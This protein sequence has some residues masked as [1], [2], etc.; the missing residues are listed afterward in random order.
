MKELGKKIL[1]IFLVISTIQSVFAQDETAGNIRGKVFSGPDGPLIGVN[2]FEIDASNRIHTSQ[3][4]NINGEFSMKVKNTANKLKVS[5][6]GYKTQLIPIGGKKVFSIELVDATTIDVVVVKARKT[7]NSGGLDIPKKEISTAMQTISS[8]EFE[9][10]SVASVDDAL[11]G[12][13]SGLDIVSNSGNTGSGASMRIRGITSINSSSEPLIVLNGIIFETNNGANMDYA[14]PNQE[15]FADLLSVNVDD[16]ESI[17]VLKDA[18]STA[19]WGS[20]GANGVISII[21]KKGFSGKTKVVYTYRFSGATQPKGM[22]MLTGDDYT[23]LLKESYF[24]PKQSDNTSNIKELNYNPLFSEYH[25]YNQNTDWVKAVTQF[26][27]TN[28]HYLQLSGGGERARFSVS[29][30]FF[31]QTGS[32]IGQLLKRYSTRMNLD[33]MVSERIKFTSEFSFTYSD[34]K[35]NIANLLSTA[36]K[37]MPNMSIYARDADGN[38]TDRFYKMLPTISSQLGDQLGYINPVA[39]GYLGQSNS[40]SIRIIPTFR[41]Q[42][43][44]I[45]PAK[46]QLRYKGH[47]SFDVNNGGGTAFIPKEL[48]TS[49][50]LSSAINASSSADYRGLSISAENSLTWV[51][52]FDNTNHSLMMFINSKFGTSTYRSQSISAYGT[53]NG[54]I[55]GP[56][57]GGYISGL[58]SSPGQGRSMSMSFVTHYAFKEKYIMDVSLTRYGST[59]FGDSRKWGTFPGVSLAWNV[60]DE[61]FMN[62]IKSWLSTFKLRPSWGIAGTEP[63]GEYLFYSL[64]SSW[65]RYIDLNAVRPDN[66]QLANLRWEKSTLYNYGFD[67]GLM[68]DAFMVYF[69]Y[70]YKRIEDMLFPNVQIPSSSGFTGL[71]FQ[72]AGTMDNNGWEINLQAN[73]LIKAGDFSVDV[74]LNFSNNVN[75]IVNIRPSILAGFNPD[76]NFEN[77]TYLTRIQEKNPYGAIYGFRYKGVYQF[78]E[79]H[80]S[81]DGT[82][83]FAFDE[84]KNVIR[85][86]EGKPLRMTFGAGRNGSLSLYDFKGGDA[87]YEDINHDGTINELDIVYLGN[88]NPLVNGG[89]NLKFNYKRFSMSVFSNFRVGNKVV[90]ANRML[91]ENMYTNNNQSASVNWRWR[92]DGDY[93]FMP[94]ALNKTGYNW[95]GSDRYVED[96]S[97]FRVKNLQINYALPS[98]TLKPYAINGLS[99][100]LTINNLFVLT[101]YSGVDPEVG[102]GGFGI[103]RDYGQTPRA[104]SFTAGLSVTF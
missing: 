56:T 71:S 44:L 88:S 37:I 23:M 4:T 1:L 77:G 98:K 87:I 95:L 33:Y 53:P 62:P 91:A 35:Q 32:V 92:K 42:Y 14:N 19:V 74:T 73:K 54:S 2:V 43:D 10:L 27:Q 16:I 5:Y 51:P 45:D 12:R 61:E 81:S 103:S 89:F 57:A 70:Y 11:Q 93:T 17:T 58:N 47:V 34:N 8:K 79:Y 60:A 82:S 46:Q 29:G 83:P 76:Y 30:G 13:I 69:D 67:L 49:D 36:Y 7:I 80:P 102:T 15:Q 59:R 85:D 28:D 39:A 22:T 48:S 25:N 72:N 75:T 52:K 101:K 99:M 6:V 3:V 9:G 97:F 24:N 40:K 20:R 68:D 94:R 104:K 21:T 26:G 31:N 100:F 55:Q 18:A 41:L 84:D 86:A 64:Y 78:T 38:P 90:N 96:G 50:W 66:I 63:G 65:G